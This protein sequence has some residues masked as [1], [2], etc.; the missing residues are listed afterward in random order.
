MATPN[1]PH[2][3]LFKRIFSRREHAESELRPAVAARLAES[4][5]IEMPITQ[6]VAAIIDGRL[7]IPTAITDRGQFPPVP[8]RLPFALHWSR[9]GVSDWP[10]GS[11]F[12]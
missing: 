5:Q 4:H 6:A 11:H 2:D 1:T 8:G 12:F 10:A 9:L 3:S 7:D